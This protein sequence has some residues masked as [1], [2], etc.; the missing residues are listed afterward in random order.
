MKGE[1]CYYRQAFT[2][3][4]CDL[5]LKLG[6]QLPQDDAK[7]GVG[8]D[9]SNNSFRRSKIR[10]IQK[11]QPQFGWLF[12]KMWKMALEANDTWFGF[13]I[14]RI[15]YIQLAEY[16]ATYQGEYK[17][18]HDVFWMNDDPYYHRKLTSVI[19]LTDPTTYK[20]GAFEVY[21]LTQYPNADEIKE[22]GTTVFIPSFMPHAAL[23]VTEGTRY[24]LACWFDGPKWR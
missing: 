15:S 3:E 24:S 10:F 22:Q 19:Q 20:G 13:H 7:L 12:D 8:G 2:P 18:H 23:P 16:D 14:S 5:I 21:D 11:E 1:W 4:E 6:L 9:V 17:K